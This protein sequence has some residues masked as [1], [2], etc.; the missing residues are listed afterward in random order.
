MD[1]LSP[2]RLITPPPDDFKAAR[3]SYP[4]LE[5]AVKS[6]FMVQ[7]KTLETDLADSG[8]S[9]WREIEPSAAYR[10]LPVISLKLQQADDED[11]Q[12]FWSRQLTLAGIRVF[13]RPVP[14]MAAKLVRQQ[15]Q[16]FPAQGGTIVKDIYRSVLRSMV[17]EPDED[18]SSDEVLLAAIRQILEKRY[19]TIYQLIDE[20][21][22]AVN[23]LGA[24][25]IRDV[26][27][28]MLDQLK[29]EDEAWQ[30]WQVVLADSAYMSVSPVQKLIKIGRHLNQLP[31]NR[32]KS[33]FT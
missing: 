19:R 21:F 29:I 30:G 25:D 8:D 4:D 33:L 3:F 14:S 22:E 6:R 11:R 15:L 23:E 12:R 1:G 16:Q 31:L 2:L 10:Y 32:A 28:R 13:G 27:S 17:V 5:L 7:F 9:F 24:A 18:E 20:R 26:Y